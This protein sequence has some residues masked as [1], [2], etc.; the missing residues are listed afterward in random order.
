MAWI[1]IEF[2]SLQNSRVEKGEISAGT[3]KNY[4]KPVKLFC[5]MNNVWVNWKFIS[6]EIK[7][8]NEIAEDRPPS[9]EELKKLIDYPDRRMKPIVLIMISSVIRIGSWDH[10][11]WRHIIP[12]KDKS[13]N[14]VIAAKITVFDTKN[15]KECFSFI[16]PEAYYSLKEWMDFRASHGEK[17]NGESWLMRN[18]WKIRSH[19]Y[20]NFMGSA[21][22]PIKFQSY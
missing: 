16:T 5:E 1:S 6:R 21:K 13:N 12:L 3:I 14:N 15:N 11:K 8:S 9:I 22:H 18:L 4:Y 19:R 17:I 2:F 7:K 10:L 20:A